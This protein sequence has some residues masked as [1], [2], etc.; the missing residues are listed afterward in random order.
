MKRRSHFHPFANFTVVQHEKRQPNGLSDILER[1]YYAGYLTKHANLII[2][3]T[4]AERGTWGQFANVHVFDTYHTDA[5]HALTWFT[6]IYN[7]ALRNNGTTMKKRN[8]YLSQLQEIEPLLSFMGLTRIFDREWDR[9]YQYDTANCLREEY[10]QRGR[11]A[12]WQNRCM[13]V[14]IPLSNYETEIMDSVVANTMRRHTDILSA[15][16]KD[17]IEILSLIYIEGLHG[18]TMG[19]DDL[20]RL[21]AMAA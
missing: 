6:D 14:D 17:M 20:Q 5:R 16:D 18:L 19:A 21:Q 10:E 12:D 3:G 13:R 9:V 11:I 7:T 1:T 2:F 4:G 8:F 15:E